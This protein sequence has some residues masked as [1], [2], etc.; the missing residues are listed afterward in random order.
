MAATPNLEEIF[1]QKKRR[2]Y[3]RTSSAVW[4]HA[5]VTHKY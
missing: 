3:K 1:V 4:G 2:F 5:P